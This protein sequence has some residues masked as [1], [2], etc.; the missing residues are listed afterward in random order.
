[1]PECAAALARLNLAARDEAEAMLLDL[2]GSRAWAAALAARRPF[3][4]REALRR[5]AE[6]AFDRLTDADWEAAFAAHPRLGAGSSGGRQSARGEAWSERE[7]AGA[8]AVDDELRER[9]AEGNRRYEE[10]FGRTYVARASGRDAHELLAILE[11]RLALDPGAEL[12]AAAA[13]QRD[14]SRLRLDR[15]FPP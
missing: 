2:C 8:Q 5:L 14:I 3:A 9:L 6:E 4:N 13:E 10:R 11:R 12:L 1:M 7:Q 15:M